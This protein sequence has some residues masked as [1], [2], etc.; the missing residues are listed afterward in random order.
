M[1]RRRRP[2]SATKSA[3][4]S[5]DGQR[6]RREQRNDSA[7]D[8]ERIAVPKRN[9]VGPAWNRQTLKRNVRGVERGG[10][11]VDRRAPV[12]VPRDAHDQRRVA[13]GFDVEIDRAAS[14]RRSQ[15]AARSGNEWRLY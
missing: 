13:R 3:G 11:P 6:G 5:D 12:F 10:R 2:F 1:W 9:V 4:N 14:L 8:D 7:D 15:D